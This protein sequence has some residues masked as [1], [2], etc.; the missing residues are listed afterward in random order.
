MSNSYWFVETD[1]S[2]SPATHE[3]AKRLGFAMEYHLR[4]LSSLEQVDSLEFYL[5]VHPPARLP[6]YGPNVVLAIVGDEYHVAY[7]YFNK[8]LA[9]L[10][11]YGARQ[12]YLDGAP[13]NVL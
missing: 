6:R 5:C 2:S 12:Q 11:C 1:G 9:V 7:S 13:F 10:R 3:A 4:V 8:I